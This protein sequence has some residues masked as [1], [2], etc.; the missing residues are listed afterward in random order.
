M[1]RVCVM[2]LCL[3]VVMSG[4]YAERD[5]I[6]NQYM[7]CHIEVKNTIKNMRDIDTIEISEQVFTWA[8]ERIES[9]IH[10]IS[11]SAHSGE[12][13]KINRSSFL[14]FVS[15]N[16][17]A[18]ENYTSCLMSG[19]D[20]LT[21]TSRFDDYQKRVEHMVEW[22]NLVLEGIDSISNTCHP[23]SF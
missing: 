3:T 10:K 6:A 4:V 13:N 18:E 8:A 19:F 15:K 11:G 5:D 23:F 20:F 21:L 1:N 2:I 12:C 9:I 17:D 14:A 16:G 22:N 7:G